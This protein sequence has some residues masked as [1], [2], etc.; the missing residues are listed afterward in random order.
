[1]KGKRCLKGLADLCLFKTRIHLGDSRLLNIFKK[2]KTSHIIKMINDAG[3]HVPN[4]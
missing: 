3:S 4:L 1:M 2:V